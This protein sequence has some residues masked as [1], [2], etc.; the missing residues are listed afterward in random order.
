MN[1]YN[2]PLLNH[3]K[4]ELEGKEFEL[5]LKEKHSR[6]TNSQYRY[7]FGGVLR[8]CYQTEMFSHF[9]K[10]DD[11]H[12]MF[13]GPKFLSY[14]KVVEVGKEKS[15]VKRVPS[16]TTITRKELGEFID[17]VIIWCAEHSI[18]ILSPEQYKLEK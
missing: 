9:D 15:L 1:F 18:V 5:V 13:F 3:C 12:E 7:Y 17:K 2:I 11:I 16:L 10:A 4:N 6:V 8:T 14:T